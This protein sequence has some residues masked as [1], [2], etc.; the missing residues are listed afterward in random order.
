M[1]QDKLTHALTMC[2]AWHSG[3]FRKYTK[4][5]YW[6]HPVKV[7]ELVK[8]VKHTEE[9]LCA[10]LLHDVV[11]DT[12]CTID[13]IRN[14]MGDDIAC[15]VEMLTN[16]SKPEDGNREQRRAINRAHTAQATPDVKTIK[17]ADVIVNLS[18]IFEQDP[19]FARIYVKEKELL[20]QVLLDGDHELL[21]MANNLI[22]NIKNKLEIG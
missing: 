3:Q 10:A 7:M 19:G 12:D 13:L 15:M 9:M 18:D 1:Q 6:T 8:T 21:D 14:P 11:E 22:N 5:P 20:L 2:K 4:E 17:L 16:P